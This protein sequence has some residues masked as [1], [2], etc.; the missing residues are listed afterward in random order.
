MQ[1]GCT[2]VYQQRWHLHAINRMSISGTCHVQMC[3]VDAQVVQLSVMACIDWAA[4]AAALL[5]L[6]PWL[7]SARPLP[8]GARDTSLSDRASFLGLALLSPWTL[9]CLLGG[10]ATARE[11]GVLADLL[12]DITGLQELT[13]PAGVLAAAVGGATGSLRLLAAS[14]VLSAVLLGVW[15]PAWLGCM[16]IAAAPVDQAA[17]RNFQP[18]TA[19]TNPPTDH[20][21]HR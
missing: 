10:I 17:Q 13:R 3:S 12:H 20:S 18:D 1:H 2:F 14:P 9:A 11:G 4:A 19:E 16:L 8:P 6:G 5:L 7:C 15:A 21:Q